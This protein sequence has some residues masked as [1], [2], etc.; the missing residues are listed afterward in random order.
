MFLLTNMP[1]VFGQPHEGSQVFGTNYVNSSSSWC[2]LHFIGATRFAE[3]VCRSH[4]SCLASRG[5]KVLWAPL[6]SVWGEEEVGKGAGCLISFWMSY[7][8]DGA[9]DDL[10]N[11]LTPRQNGEGWFIKHPIPILVCFSIFIS[12]KHKLQLFLKVLDLSSQEANFF[13]NFLWWDSE[14][15]G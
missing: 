15:G 8:K 13:F 10:L 7:V 3:V 1:R 4:A 2:L 9:I 5:C 6:C 11:V 12:Q 14:D